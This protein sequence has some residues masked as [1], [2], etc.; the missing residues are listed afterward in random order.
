MKATD[1]KTRKLL[2]TGGFHPKSSTLGLN[3]KR[4]EIG[5]ELVSVKAAIQD[6]TTKIREY[7]R[8][9]APTDDMLG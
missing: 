5:Q 2:T 1:I 7:I 6:E 3:I 4:K 9:M 8:K